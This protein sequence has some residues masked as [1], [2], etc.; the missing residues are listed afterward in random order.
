VDV[1]EVDVD[2]VDVA[3]G[4]VVEEEPGVVDVGIDAERVVVVSAPGSAPAGVDV[5]ARL[6]AARLSD[7][8]PTR[9]TK[10]GHALLCRDRETARV[11]AIGV[12]G[13]GVCENA[14]PGAT[15]RLPGWSN[16]WIVRFS[17]QP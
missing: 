13:M 2:E 12:G 6:T 7:A 14:R 17:G 16:L 9:A 5:A 15:L 10:E 8:S 3:V 4:V 1:D 11:G